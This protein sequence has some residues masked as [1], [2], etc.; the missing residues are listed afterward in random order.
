VDLELL[1]A[2]ADARP[3]WHVVLLG[4]IETL[5]NT[6]L[7]QRP[8]LHLL[9]PKPYQQLPAY[10]AGWDVALLPFA[11]NA[12]TRYLS[13]A[14]TLE[15]LAAGRPVVSTSIEDVMWPYAE[16]GVARI[17]DEPEAFAAAIEAA[18]PDRE[19]PNWRA[20]V[21]ALLADVSWDQTVENMQRLMRAV[22]DQ[23]AARAQQAALLAPVEHPAPFTQPPAAGRLA[24]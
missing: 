3:D 11:R 22:G 7:P 12:A 24:V 20:A 10:A 13:P 17:A 1:V 2:L 15:Y 9:G 21:A 14:Q 8:N 4:P 18:M 6:D 23:T 16:A 5:D 19:D